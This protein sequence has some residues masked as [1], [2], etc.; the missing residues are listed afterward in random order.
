[1]AIF[2]KEACVFKYDDSEEYK[3]RYHLTFHD[4]KL[5]ELFISY[6]EKSKTTT[7]DDQVGITTA[8]KGYDCVTN[9][10][11]KTVSLF[12]TWGLEH[13]I[14]K[15]FLETKLDPP[16]NYI[17]LLPNYNPKY[18]QPIPT[19]TEDPERYAR[20]TTSLPIAHSGI[21]NIP[22]E[23]IN[24][25]QA[26]QPPTGEKIGYG[27]LFFGVSAPSV[28]ALTA[29]C[30]DVEQNQKL[31][32]LLPDGAF[33]DHVITALMATGPHGHNYTTGIS[34]AVLVLLALLALT[35]AYPEKWQK[36]K[37]YVGDAVN[38]CGDTLYFIGANTSDDKNLLGRPDK[39][40][41]FGA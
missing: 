21:L 1:M 15:F 5:Y 14:G 6:C 9:N 39:E 10:Q 35:V 16:P 32:S 2:K 31:F 40:G 25:L 20:G 36:L 13:F 23:I 28:T 4:P 37:D 22:Q 27:L 24:E 12:C 33:K 30:L 11:E 26:Y 38:S 3:P 41:I 7:T 18:K 19:D 8:F 17:A 34:I 29:S